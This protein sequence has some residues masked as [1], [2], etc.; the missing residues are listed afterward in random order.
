MMQTIK[1]FGRSLSEFYL[2][3]TSHYDSA[4]YDKRGRK[5]AVQRI[6]LRIQ[7]ND[8]AVSCFYKIAVGAA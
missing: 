4:P 7:M 3:I 6:P 1:S 5:L 2:N 8:V